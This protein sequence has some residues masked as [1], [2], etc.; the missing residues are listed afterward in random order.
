[1]TTQV[2]PVCYLRMLD[3]TPD[4]DEHCVNETPDDLLLGLEGENGYSVA[5]LYAAPRRELPGI[6]GLHAVIS[7]QCRAN[8]TDIGAIDEAL[9]H[10]RAEMIATLPFRPTGSGTLLHVIFTVEP[11]DTHE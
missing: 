8:R 1:M 10:V 7:D 6:V 11:K 4:W 3:G 5:P 2:K 9:A